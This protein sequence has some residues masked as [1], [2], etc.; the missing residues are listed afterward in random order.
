M[1]GGPEK[2]VWLLEKFLDFSTHDVHKAMSVAPLQ[3]GLGGLCGLHL[4]LE[5]GDDGFCQGCRRVWRDEVSRFK[6]GDDFWNASGGCS[7]KGI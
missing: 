2:I 1:R 4:V 6:I 7:E 5:N 3:G